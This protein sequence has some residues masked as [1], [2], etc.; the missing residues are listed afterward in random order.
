VEQQQKVEGKAF[1]NGNSVF[2]N[3]IFVF[4]KI[5]NRLSN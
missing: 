1:N 2:F 5:D 4:V 3:Q